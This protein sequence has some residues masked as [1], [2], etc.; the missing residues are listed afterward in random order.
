MQQVE[1]GKLDLDA[2]VNTYLD[3]KVPEA[4]GK[5]ITLRDIMTHTPGYED[6]AKD[7]IVA[8]PKG[9]V[10]LG[11]HLRTHQPQRIF[12]PGSTPAYSNYATSMAGYIVER[13]S[14]KPF[15][16]YVDEFIMGPLGMKHATFRQPSP[17]GCSRR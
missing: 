11:Q 14:G 17:G 3:F 8:D 6:Y 12:P 13:V 1:Q 7:L 16:E 2:D 5:P 4:F 15:A 10:P 9:L